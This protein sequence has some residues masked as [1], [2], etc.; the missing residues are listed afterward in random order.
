MRDIPSYDQYALSAYPHLPKVQELWWH[1]HG[2]GTYIF[3]LWKWDSPA[4]RIF[5]SIVYLPCF[6][7]VVCWWVF[8]PLQAML[9]SLVSTSICVWFSHSSVLTEISVNIH[10]GIGGGRFLHLLLKGGRD[11]ELITPAT[12]WVGVI[13]LLFSL[14]SKKDLQIRTFSSEKKEQHRRDKLE[15]WNNKNKQHEQKW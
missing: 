15:P 4:L 5:F 9:F 8:V 14:T 2:E 3:I 10:S 1:W 11:L 7:W 6:A 12:L 13:S